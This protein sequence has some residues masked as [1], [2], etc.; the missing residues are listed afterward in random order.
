MTYRE[1]V[2]VKSWSSAHG[3]RA[4]NLFAKGTQRDDGCC[5]G[6][7][8]TSGSWTSIFGKNNSRVLSIPPRHAGTGGTQDCYP[9]IVFSSSPC[10]LWT[11]ESE[12]KMRELH[13][14]ALRPRIHSAMSLILSPSGRGNTLQWRKLGT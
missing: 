13:E 2:T 14:Q 7:S 6:A 8:E 5:D 3:K 9:R 10:T 11:C 4:L 12:I 1:Q